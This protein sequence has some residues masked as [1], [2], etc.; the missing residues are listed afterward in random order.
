[1]CRGKPTCTELGPREA[2]SDR[3]PLP[4]PGWIRDEFVRVRAAFEAAAAGDVRAAIDAIALFP[5]EAVRQWCIE[6]GQGSGRM[7][8]RA[9]GK[10]AA[11]VAGAPSGP[12]EANRAVQVVVLERDR[13]QCRYCGIP[14]VPR[15]MFVAFGAVVGPTHF[16]TERENARRHGARLVFGAQVDHVT[17]YS[18]GGQSTPDNLVT[19]CW[20]CNFG[21]ARFHVAQLAISDPRD[22]PPSTEP[23]DGF[24]S[25]LPALRAARR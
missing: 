11:P 8:H 25:L 24:V 4:P 3:A 18:L 14:V 2:W 23:R 12:R 10:P 9:L 21:K 22:W 7:R 5:D 1:M 6:H 16:P 17:P 15:A 20:S 19:S 13:Y